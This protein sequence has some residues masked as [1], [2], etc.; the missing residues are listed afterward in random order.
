MFNSE[1]VIIT[2]IVSIIHYENDR[3]KR[4]IDYN[5]HGY[6]SK[7]Y[8]LVYKF[9]GRVKT[10][11]NEKI[12][13]NGPDTVFILPKVDG[14]YKYTN[15]FYEFGG[16]ID[17]FFDTSS[18]MPADAENLPAGNNK[19]LKSLFQK[20]YNIWRLKKDGYY[21]K[22]MSVLYEIIA[23]LQNI[24]LY[25]TSRQ[26]TQIEPGLNYLHENFCKNDFDAKILPNL[27]KIS[28]SYFKTLFIKKYGVTPS[29]YI[30]QLK[31]KR[32]CDLLVSNTYS[33]TRISEL[34]GYENVY[35]F[36]RV[37]KKETGCTPL[38]FKFND[39]L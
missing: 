28:Y 14:P 8:E 26:W 5:A 1:K 15:E 29:K 23:E 20:I 6:Q 13:L 11:F 30:T 25:I 35:Y 32:A 21:A 2:N 27:C 16:G 17:I 33:V 10:T 38:Q 3:S 7:M 37:F 22:A 36:S 31:I 24:D 39:N 34:L 4:Y 19:N 12:L 18:P 9:S